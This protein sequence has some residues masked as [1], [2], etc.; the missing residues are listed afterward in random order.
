MR[1]QGID[2][3]RLF[4]C[5]CLF[6]LHYCSYG[7]GS[8]TLTEQ[9]VCTVIQS[10]LQY[11]IGFF[12]MISGALF[13]GRETVDIKKLYK[14]NIAHMVFVYVFWSGIYALF[15]VIL[16]YQNVT[17]VKSL[18]IWLLMDIR[19]SH[20][21]LWF[22]PMI[23]G[24]YII[25]PTMQAAFGGGKNMEILKYTAGVFIVFGPVVDTLRL[26]PFKNDTFHIL[27]DKITVGSFAGWLGFFLFGHLLYLNRD[28]ITDKQIKICLFASVLSAIVTVAVDLYKVPEVGLNVFV[29]YVTIPA[30]IIESTVFLLFIRIKPLKDEK[31]AAYLAIAADCML[32]VYGIHDLVMSLVNMVFGS[33]PDEM[34]LIKMLIVIP[35]S[36]AVSFGIVILMRKSKLLKLIAV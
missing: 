24:I 12:L 26:I 25:A 35:V 34:Y 36:F 18:A 5:F 11:P 27:L 1:D 20:Y 7:I 14:H 17:D 10:L 32:G 8:Q 21:H 9:Y 23:I 2:W 6:P 33:I 13:L 29:S 31:K 15:D 4:G 22:L 3:C 28:K 19:D 16:N 30:L